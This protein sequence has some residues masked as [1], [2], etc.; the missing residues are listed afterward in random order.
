MGKAWKPTHTLT[1]EL[2]SWEGL[3]PECTTCGL[4]SP[5]T[6]IPHWHL[7]PASTCCAQADR[8]VAILPGIVCSTVPHAKLHI[9]WGFSAQVHFLGC[10][11]T[12]KLRIWVPAA[13]G[14]SSL[15]L[16][17]FC[18]WR[19]SQDQ[20]IWVSL[21]GQY[22][23]GTSKDTE[24]HNVYISWTFSSCLTLPCF[25][26]QEIFPCNITNCT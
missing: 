11:S 23:R 8:A 22:R 2:Q 16:A 19:L 6:R 26:L 20:N 9:W 7:T 15:H 4:Y 13:S 17:R 5:W 25:S 3:L 21:K 1:A 10:L 14:L 24:I 18:H 12:E